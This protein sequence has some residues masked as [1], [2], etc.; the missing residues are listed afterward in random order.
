MP[1]KDPFKELEKMQDRM[2]RL[3]KSFWEKGPEMAGFKSFPVDVSEENGKVV[4]E[5]DMPG[6][7]KENIAVKARDNQLMISG[8]EESEEKE[9]KENYY[10]RER[11]RTGLKRTVTLP[12][13]VAEEEAEAEMKD[14]VLR[15]TLPKKKKA[16]EKEKEIEVQ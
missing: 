5:A 4:V 6:V 11:R 9:E 2:N 7:S 1:I 16:V 10:R 13:D 14:G 8:Q 12:E 3:M 15:V